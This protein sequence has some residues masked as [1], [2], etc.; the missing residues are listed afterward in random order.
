MELLGKQ[1]PAKWLLFGY[2]VP[3][4]PSRIRVRL[5]RQL[6]S[7]GAL[8]PQMSF[9]ILPDSKDVRTRLHTLRSNANE[10]GSNVTL[11]AKAIDQRN[12]RTVFELFKE[13]LEKEYRELEEE[14]GEF[15]EEIK[16]NL[17]TGNLSQTEVSELEHALDGLERWFSSIRSRDF[18]GSTAQRK[19]RRLLNRCRNALLSFSEKAQPRLQNVSKT[20][21]SAR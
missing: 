1:T 6:K 12:F 2:D 13:D 14:C 3:D 11:E 16:N 15:T 9:C 18:V 20:G 21:S 19:N 4:E 5:W 10:F 7:L 8:Y 17:A